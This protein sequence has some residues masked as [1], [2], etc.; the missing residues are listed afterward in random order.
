MRSWP[1]LS[2]WAAASGI[3]YHAKDRTDATGVTAWTFESV[4]ISI[5]P[6]SM[7]LVRIT[8][9]KVL[10]TKKLEEILRIIPVL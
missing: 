4:E 1:S 9:A 8:V 2:V 3:R 7:I 6:T 5:Q 10:E